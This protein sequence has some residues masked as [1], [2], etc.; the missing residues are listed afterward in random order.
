MIPVRLEMKNF[1]PYRQPDPLYFEGIHLACLTG[2]NGAGK[3]SLL[4]AITWALWGKARAVRDDDLVHLGQSDMHVV[5]DFEQEGVLYRV[6]R[7]RTAGKRGQGSLALFTVQEDGALQTITAPSMRETQHTINSIL[8]LDYETFVNSA[9][10]QQGKAD[11][12]TTKRPAERKRILSDI[13]GLEQWR[14][15]EERT[16]EEIKQIRVEIAGLDGAIHEIDEQLKHEPQHRRDLERYT[17]EYEAADA[18]LQAAIKS[19]NEVA[20][21]ENDLKNTQRQQGD[22]S[23]R[24]NDYKNDLKAAKE[25]IAQREERVQAFDALIARKEDIL[26]GYEQ[27]KSAQKAN[28]ELADVMRADGDFRERIRNLET[29]IETIKSDLI[30]QRSGYEAELRQI[31]TLMVDDVSEQLAELQADI[32]RLTTLQKERDATNDQITQLREEAGTIAGEFTVLKQQGIELNERIDALRESDEGTCPLCGQ[33]LDDDHRL[34]VIEETEAERNFLRDKWTKN[35]ERQAEIDGEIKDLQVQVKAWGDEL[36]NLPRLQG[37]EGELQSKLTQAQNARD[38]HALIS[39]NLADIMQKLEGDDYAHDLREQRTQLQK[40]REQL[41]YDDSQHD[42]L[43]SQIEAY[44]GYEREHFELEQAEEALPHEREMLANARKRHARYAET[45]RTEEKTLET[46]AEEIKTLQAQVQEYRRREQDV[47]KHRKIVNDA[48]NNRISAQQ[49]LNALEQMRQRRAEKEQQISQ[50]REQ[51]A[52]YVQ[53]SQAFGKNGVPAMIIE[54]AIPEL[55]DAANHLLSRMT[56][57]RMH[58]RLTTQ[59]ANVDG[60]NRETL[61]IEIADELGTRAY[62]MYSG[63]ESFRI[64]FALRVALSEMLARRAGAHLRTLFIDEGFG[65]QDDDG[66]NKLVEAITSI[67]EEFDLILVITHIDELRDAFPVHI[68]VEKTGT[69]SAIMVR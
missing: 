20:H 30:A 58:L 26:A 55:E 23:A 21:A 2:H 47:N 28:R 69:G 68:V 29:Q 38:Q 39:A 65:T 8:R 54:S 34:Q 61:D 53:L 6:N 44:E 11:A 10:L 14:K 60:S 5:L 62:E 13:L 7:Q 59:R 31:E 35:R 3:S 22:T 1:L 33:T 40:E 50:A 25:E 27:L 24:L 32:T 12:F 19:M 46:Y 67:Q 48:N 36:A 4:D 49:S 18:E 42:A 66:R 52:L 56:D 41:A 15:Y 17:A 16:K 45:I 64:N 51:E 9:Y 63:G 57:G 43:N 37:R